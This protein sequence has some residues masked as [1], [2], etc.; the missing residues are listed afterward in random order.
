MNLEG[1]PALH[2]ALVLM[3]YYIG[4][5]MN[6]LSAA[7]LSIS[8]NNNGVSTIRQYF[9]LRWPP[10]MV[11]WAVCT[12]VFLIGW[13]N[14]AINLERFMPTFT[15]HV[16]VAGMLGFA[17]DEFTSKVLALLGIQKDLPA[18]PPQP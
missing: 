5:L 7:H 15:M 4:L 6:V 8:S 1:H 10:L 2:Y 14:P 18:V 12:F 11:R 3:A 17:S 9:S 16:G 13:G